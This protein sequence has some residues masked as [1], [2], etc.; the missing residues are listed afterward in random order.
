SAA[1]SVSRTAQQRGDVG[2]ATDAEAAVEQQRAELAAKLAE[3][4]EAIRRAPEP[5][6]ETIELKA[7]KA[8]T[9]VTRVALLWLSAT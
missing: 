5:A 7:R 2:R 1:R 3:D 8:D 6:I 4:C 9:A